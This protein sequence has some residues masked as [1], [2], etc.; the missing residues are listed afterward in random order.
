[1]RLFFDPT[2]LQPDNTL[3]L[4]DEDH[5]YLTKVLRKREGDS[6]TLCDGRAN[7]YPATIQTIDKKRTTLTLEPPQPNPNEPATRVT[8]VAG[9][10][11]GSKIDTIIQKTVELGVTEL[12]FVQTTRSDVNKKDLDKP[13]K[14]ERLH[15]I[16]LA[17]AQ[18][19]QRGV[20][21]TITLSTFEQLVAQFTADTNP[22]KA[23]IL[24][25]EAEA[26]NGI[27]SV[28]ERTQAPSH[29]YLFTGPEGGLTTDEVALATAAG[30]H[31]ASLG[32][33]ILR[34]ETAGIVGVGLVMYHLGEME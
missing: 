3:T 27:R 9:I 14:R 17:A 20:V 25:Y 7:D 21:P 5:D 32:K 11:K 18:Q 1:M 2:T 24:F 30:I 4:S 29:V 22:T 8:L 12:V 31:T 16:A 10:P 23:G 28:L 6:L 15:K 13:A 33:R 26:G 34:T 19:S